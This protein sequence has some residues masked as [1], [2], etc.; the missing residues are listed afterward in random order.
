MIDVL[1]EEMKVSLKEIEEK[2]NIRLEEI[3]KFLEERHENQEKNN[4]TGERNSLRL[5]N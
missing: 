3:N 2:A 5:E 1:K 4:Q